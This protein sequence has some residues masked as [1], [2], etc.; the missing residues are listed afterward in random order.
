VTTTRRLNGGQ[1]CWIKSQD[2]SGHSSSWSKYPFVLVVVLSQFSFFV[3]FCFV[4]S[5]GDG[6]QGLTDARQDP[7][8]IF[9][10]W[11][12]VLLS[13]DPLVSA[14]W[15]GRI[16]GVCHRASLLRPIWILFLS[17]ATQ[18]VLWYSFHNCN[19]DSLSFLQ[20]W[21]LNSGLC[22]HKAGTISLEPCL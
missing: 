13:C 1:M 2:T 16:T 14:S 21:S 7:C 10:F 17:L 4:C 15:E 20:V 8:Y 12:R 9:F 22:T 18:I 6:T 11:Y 3:L 5:A 19:K